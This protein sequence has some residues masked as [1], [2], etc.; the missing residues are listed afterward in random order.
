MALLASIRVHALGLYN[1]PTADLSLACSG[2]GTC[3]YQSGTCVCFK[4]W[5]APTDVTQYRQGDCAART[6]PSHASWTS[7]P[8]SDVLAHS[9][10]AE[11]S[12]MG[13]CDRSAGTC[14]C[15]EGFTGDACQRKSCP[16]AIRG[17]DCSG[18]GSCVSMK[19]AASMSNAMPVGASAT[20]GSEAT[21]HTRA[22]DANMMYGC[23][24]DSSW[25]V[26]IGSGE[27]QVA[28]YWGPD[29]SQRRC[30]SADN[31]M[32]SGDE[33]DC[34]GVNGG[35]AGNLCHVECSQ[36]GICDYSSGTCKCFAGFYG[37]AC[38]RQSVLALQM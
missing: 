21:Y 30:P 24:C 20:Y 38:A 31:P 11:C 15:F 23:V 4:G 14:S 10:V 9:V 28:E 26:G 16:T 3:E 18:H 7:T 25:S 19:Q 5:G 17:V 33:T 12:D 2:H 22:W 36:N 35:S 13:V 29:C 8:L 37:E 6:C 32:T 27:T 34:E 1:C